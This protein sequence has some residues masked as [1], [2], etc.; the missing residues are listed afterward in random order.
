LQ[1]QLTCPFRNRQI[2]RLASISCCFFIAF[3]EKNWWL[4]IGNGN[5]FKLGVFNALDI[6]DQLP[7]IQHSHWTRDQDLF[8]A[9]QAGVSVLTIPTE[10]IRHI[11]IDT[12]RQ[13]G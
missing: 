9:I 1:G 8:G 7:Q 4:E 10:Q 5:W 3:I 2:E 13:V 6:N 11:V 12:V